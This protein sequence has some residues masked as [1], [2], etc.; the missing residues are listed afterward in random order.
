M[1]FAFLYV[2]LGYAKRFEVSTNTYTK[3]IN[4]LSVEYRRVDL[5]TL[6]FGKYFK[7]RTSYLVIFIMFIS[8]III[9]IVLII[10][11]K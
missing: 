2:V 6:H 1:S 3:I 9:N 7:L 11:E 4:K 10:T 8:L 5:F